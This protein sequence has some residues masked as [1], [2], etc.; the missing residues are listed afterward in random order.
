MK[1]NRFVLLSL[2]SLLIVSC[3]NSNSFE[4]TDSSDIS[5]EEN[6]SSTNNEFQPVTLD[7][8]KSFIKIDLDDYVRSMN[9]ESLD[10]VTL[11]KINNHVEICKNEIDLANDFTEVKEAFEN[12]KEKIANEIP[13]ANGFISLDG[14]LNTIGALEAYA[15]RNS[16]TGLTLFEN[17]NYEVYSDRITLGTNTY[18]SNYGFGLLEE[19]SI[20]GSIDFQSNSAWKEYLHISE[21][22]DNLDISSAVRNHYNKYFNYIT[23]S[24][25]QDFLNDDKTS[26]QTYNV[27]ANSDLIPMDLDEN[28]EATIFK[29][30]VKT[31]KGG[32]KYTTN[33]TLESRIPFNNRPV[34]LEDYLTIFKAHLNPKN[35]L[36]DST[37]LNMFTSYTFSRIKGAWDYYQASKEGPADFNNVGIKV[38]EENGKNYL[39]F[40]M[41]EPINQ[42]IMKY[43][44]NEN[45]YQPV[46]QEFLDVIGAENYFKADLDNGIKLMDNCLSLGAYSIEQCC[47]DTKLVLKKNQNYVYDNEKYNIK[48]IHIDYAEYNSTIL[49]RFDSK[50]IDY[51]PLTFR[52][53]DK[54]ENY[55][56]FVIVGGDSTFSLNVNS[57]DEDSWVYLFGENGTVYNTPKSDYWKVEPALSNDHFL[58]ALSLSINRKEFATMNDATP[59]YSYLSSNHFYGINYNDSEEHQNAVFSKISNT[60]NYGYN[61][62][63]A[64]EYFK[65]ALQEL[66]NENKYVRGTED[67]PTIINLEIAWLYPSH[68]KQYHNYIKDYFETAF[69]H[70]SVSGNT[71]K[72]NIEFWISSYAYDIYDIYDY[73]YYTGQYDLGFY[74][75]IGPTLSSY[76]PFDTLSSDLKINKS[77][78]VNWSLNT[79]DVEKDYIVY[80]GKRWSYDAFISSLE[81]ASFIENG[82]LIDPVSFKLESQI[83]NDDGSYTSTLNIDFIDG[84]EVSINDVI[85]GWYSGKY[86]EKSVLENVKITKNEIDNS[87]NFTIN[88]P[89]ED[90]IE[91]NGDMGFSVY[92]TINE[93][94][95]TYSDF[96]STFGYFGSLN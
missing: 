21:T 73:K 96:V 11:S 13:L 26:I 70:E 74:K 30:E 44:I 18:F 17:G 63:L 83:K 94:E 5:I 53:I 92:F 61:L 86:K 56:N 78:A 77:F 75:I 1:R 84:Y 29:M 33:S 41:T 93:Q 47:D 16:L 4:S 36:H 49:D 58:K 52:D 20:N 32:L 64:R 80:E 25:Y 38:F 69:N 23:S 71:Y 28:N 6:S 81:N 3:D 27:L 45:A 40:E 59:Y 42:G 15:E 67:N 22:K 62:E 82:S 90:V 31:G 89:S 88:T 14:N 43:Y 34:E 57:L 2:L 72:L 50:H 39:Q 19:G 85:M 87:Y 60:D 91:Y 9:F 79:N 68:E 66:E 8:Y 24:Y 7:E 35:N 51:A 46:P 48:G 76:H 95:V 37:L 54:Y 10:E 55:K 65:V 12:V